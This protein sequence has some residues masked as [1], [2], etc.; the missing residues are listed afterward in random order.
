MN[1]DNTFIVIYYEKKV[2]GMLV[3]YIA[4]KQTVNVTKEKRQVHSLLALVNIYIIIVI[5][6]LMT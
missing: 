2:N 6:G 5:V 1:I 4:K 3:C